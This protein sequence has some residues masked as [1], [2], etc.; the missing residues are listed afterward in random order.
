MSIWGIQDFEGIIEAASFAFM[1]LCLDDQS[2][3]WLC[4]RPS[5]RHLGGGGHVP[6]V[7]R[8][9]TVAHAWLCHAFVKDKKPAF[10]VSP[11]WSYIHCEMV[12]PCGKLLG[13]T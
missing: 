1:P 13:Y 11:A 4:V 3:M 9:R 12:T 5:R 2:K 10:L 6:A 7:I 8:G